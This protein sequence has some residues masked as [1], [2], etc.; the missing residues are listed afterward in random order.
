[1]RA[2]GGSPP[3]RNSVTHDEPHTSRTKNWL[4]WDVITVD[5]LDLG[6]M[7]EG[8]ESSLSSPVSPSLSRLGF[9]SKKSLGRFTSF[10]LRSMSPR[11]SPKLV[12]LTLFNY[13]K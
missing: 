4:L 2:N 8:C 1:M 3:W 13:Q 9:W 12:S 5:G 11:W 10:G 6:N 7:S